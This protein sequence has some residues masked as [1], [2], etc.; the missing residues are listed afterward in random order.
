MRGDFDLLT[1]TTA[2]CDKANRIEIPSRFFCALY[3]YRDCRLRK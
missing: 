3:L 1:L 2:G